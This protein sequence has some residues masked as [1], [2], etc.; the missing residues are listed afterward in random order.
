MSRLVPF[1]DFEYLLVSDSYL[2]ALLSDKNRFLIPSYLKELQASEKV[3]T[4]KTK[5]EK[6]VKNNPKL[7]M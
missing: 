4:P 7:K 6:N 2:S 3:P 1:L 5:S